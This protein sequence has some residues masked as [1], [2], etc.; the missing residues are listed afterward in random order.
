MGGVKRGIRFDKGSRCAINKNKNGT[1]AITQGG[2]VVSNMAVITLKQCLFEVDSEAQ[3]AVAAAGRRGTVHAYITGFWT[4][5]ICE[6]GDPVDYNPLRFAHFF[7]VSDLNP[8]YEARY[9]RFDRTG[10]FCII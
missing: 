5:E 3:K 6:G 9:V 8:I 4:D 1:W 2:I 7:K 10:A